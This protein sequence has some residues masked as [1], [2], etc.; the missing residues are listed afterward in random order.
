MSYVIIV[1]NTQKGVICTMKNY[2]EIIKEL[3][4]DNDLLQKDIAKILNLDTSYYGKY[5][6]G[7]IPLP[8]E[9]LKTICKYYNVSADYILGFTDTPIPLP[10]K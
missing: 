7:I 3:R 2:N 8:I 6:R 9:H 5:E 4:E 10:Q 1:K